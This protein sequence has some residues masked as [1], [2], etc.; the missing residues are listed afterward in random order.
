[1]TSFGAF[2]CT[3]ETSLPLSKLYHQMQHHPCQFK[4]DRPIKAGRIRPNTIEGSKLY[5]NMYLKKHTGQTLIFK[6]MLTAPPIEI[7]SFM[8]LCLPRIEKLHLK[9]KCVLRLRELV[10]CRILFLITPLSSRSPNYEL[11]LDVALH[12]RLMLMNHLLDSTCSK[13]EYTSGVK[14]FIVTLLK[15]TRCLMATLQCL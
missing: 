8:L 10:L 15:A 7:L 9:S 2:K 13:A 4:P 12:T 6:L 1:M 3:Q 14:I 5:S 11:P